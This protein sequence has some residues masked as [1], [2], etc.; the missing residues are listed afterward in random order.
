L[1]VIINQN[2]PLRAKKNKKIRNSLFVELNK[3][4]LIIVLNRVIFDLFINYAF[5]PDA[6]EELASA[7]T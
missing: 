1:S 3:K 4:F 5:A 7:K 2:A 6:C